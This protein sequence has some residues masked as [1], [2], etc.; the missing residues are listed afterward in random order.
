MTEVRVSKT[1]RHPLL[2]ARAKTMR[3]NLTPA[4]LKLWKAL[5]QRMPLNDTHF[6]R[7][8][9]LGRFIVDFCCLGAK[10]IIKVDGDQHGFDGRRAANAERTRTLE[11][12]GFRV[13]RFSNA[14]VLREIDSVLDTIRAAVAAPEVEVAASAALEM[15]R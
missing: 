6:R 10:L 2:T 4:E 5:R 11:A 7:Q 12:D 8:V 15:K 9:R 3:A 1:D 14:D 13:L